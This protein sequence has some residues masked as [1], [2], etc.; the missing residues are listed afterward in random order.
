L[1]CGRRTK[2]GRSCR[3]PVARAGDTCAWHRTQSV[4]SE[5]TNQP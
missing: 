1:R 2:S 5:R 3:T 4:P